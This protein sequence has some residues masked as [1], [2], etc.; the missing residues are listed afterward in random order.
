M[1]TRPRYAPERA[2]DGEAAGQRDTLNFRA[3]IQAEQPAGP[4]GD[5]LLD[6][7]QEVATVAAPGVQ[8]CGVSGWSDVRAVW[9]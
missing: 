6:A 7:G 3:G 1:A 5:R 9:P 8:P 2:M 4:G